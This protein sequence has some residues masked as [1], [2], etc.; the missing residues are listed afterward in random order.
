VVDALEHWKAHPIF[1]PAAVVVKGVLV[2][3]PDC[4]TGPRSKRAGDVDPVV[5]DVEDCP[6][7]DVVVVELCPLAEIVEV[8]DDCPVVGAVVVVVE[9]LAPPVPATVVV[10]DPDPLGMTY[11]FEPPE[12]EDWLAPTVW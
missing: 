6:P 9:S 1:H 3:P 5:V 7:P 11:A 12:P 4:C 8:V 2:Y 10:V